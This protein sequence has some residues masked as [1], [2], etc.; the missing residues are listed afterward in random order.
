[1]KKIIMT[2]MLLLTAMSNIQAQEIYTEVKRMAQANVD[3]SNAD[4][5]IRQ[6]NKF[7]LDA[8][9][10]MA[11]KMREEMPDSTAEFLDKEA[12]SLHIFITN[13]TNSLVSNSQQ[14]AAHQMKVIK[15]YMDASYSNPL[16]NDNDKEIVLAYFNDGNN[17]TRFSLD[18]DWRRAVLAAEEAMKKL[19]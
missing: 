1:M 15:A 7:K 8:L 4:P 6:I 12:L 19:K 2:L 10:Y 14:P 17:L 13:Y 18:T 3:N 9:N 5:L 11:M 16:F